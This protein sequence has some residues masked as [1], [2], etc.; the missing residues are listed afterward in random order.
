M[1][2]TKIQTQTLEQI[3]R[4]K[5]DYIEILQRGLG[6]AIARL[7]QLERERLERERKRLERKRASLLQHTEAL[8]GQIRE[9]GISIPDDIPPSDLAALG[10]YII[11]PK[12]ADIAER[13]IETETRLE[14]LASDAT[15][16][17]LSD[18][19]LLAWVAVEQSGDR[20]T[21]S[22]L[23]PR[24]KGSRSK[25]GSGS[26]STLYRVVVGESFSPVGPSDIGEGTEYTALARTYVALFDGRVL[27][28]SAIKFAIRAAMAR[29]Q[30]SSL[31]S[32]STKMGQS[33]LAKAGLS[34]EA[35]PADGDEQP[36]PLP[37]VARAILA[38]DP[39]LAKAIHSLPDELRGKLG[40][41]EGVPLPLP[42]AEEQ[43]QQEQPEAEEPEE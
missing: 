3:I 15:R 1:S 17:L 14:S 38:Y 35:Q 36:V 41:P 26:K 21:I 19:N 5:D 31:D 25:S 16:S 4:K 6:R 43:E 33:H 40:W 20:I 34:F 8:K 13:L 11:G 24:Y 42:A 37:E 2:Q 9:K 32:T 22:I 29:L 10:R 39:G 23:Q 27:S 28:H 7:L 18:L 12:A 30:P